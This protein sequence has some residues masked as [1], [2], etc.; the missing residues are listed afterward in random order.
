MKALN[1]D[2]PLLDYT[3]LP[4]VPT[5]VIMPVVYRK[6]FRHLSDKTRIRQSEYMREALRD[7]LVKY[8]HEFKGS[9]F[10]F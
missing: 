1:A 10:E 3:D 7:L 2:K 5:N 4:G 9:E 6:M 8:R